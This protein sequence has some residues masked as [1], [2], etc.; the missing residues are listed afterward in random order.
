LREAWDEL[1]AGGRFL[2]VKL[3]G[4]GF[5]VGVS[6]LLVQRALAEHA[7]LDAKRLAQRMMGWTDANAPPPVPRATWRCC[8]RPTAA[9]RRSGQPYPF[10]LAHALQAGVETRRWGADWLVEWKYDGIRAQVVRRRAR[11]GSGRAARNWSPSASRRSWRWRGALPDGTVL[12]GELLAWRPGAAAAGA[13][14][15]AAAAHRPQDAD[16]EGAGRGAG[17]LR[18]LRP[19]GG[20]RAS[21]CAAPQHERRARLEALAGRRA[22]RCRRCVRPPTGRRWPP[23]TQSRERG[24]E[25]FML[26]H[27]E[28]PTAAAAP[29]PTAPGGSGRSS[30]CRSTAC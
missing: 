26:K 8:R 25:G 23:A 27:R 19:A 11:C 15:A 2:L 7:G 20:R 29:R 16:E 30:R 21:T 24:V 3:I 10:F 22:L 6:K 5:R 9:A 13:L 17:A 1:D 12:D 4:G 18:R 14:R 28:S